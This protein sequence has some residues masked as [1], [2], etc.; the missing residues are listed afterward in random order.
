MKFIFDNSYARE[1]KGFYESSLP[2]AS[3]APE[4][5]YF[6][7]SLANQL[8]LNQQNLNA[9]E[10]A[11]IFSGNRLPE[12]AEPIAQ[13]YAGHQFGQF[14]PQ[15]G[16]GRALILGEI[17]DNDKNRF[18]IC[19]KG[20]G[21]TP[22]SR[23]GDGKAAL[24]AMLREVLIAEAMHA[25]GI[26]TTRSLAVVGTGEQVFRDP[27]QPGAVL[28][29][30]A[31]SHIRIG[32]FQFFAAREQYDKVKTLADYSI[33]RHD[34]DLI[35]DKQR[36]VKFL[37]A[38]INRQAS[39]IAKW[40]GV[41]F[42][43][44]V[45]NT[46][47]ITIAGE[48]IDYGPCAFMENYDP[49]AVFSSI[50]HQGRYAYGNQPAIAQW[51]LARLAE[52]LIPL[53]DSDKDKA[54]EIATEELNGFALAYQNQLRKVMRQKLGLKADNQSLNDTDDKLVTDWLDLLEKNTVD[55]TLAFRSLCDMA[56]GNSEKLLDLFADKPDV[57]LWLAEW[58]KRCKSEGALW[59][60]TDSANESRAN[61]MRKVNPWIIPRNHR[62]EEA[63]Q[64]ASDLNNF[65]LFE[66]LLAAL[67]QP[68]I[69]QTKFESLAIP[70]SAS[71]TD[72]Y[73][74]FCGT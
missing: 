72:N 54:V 32:T 8:Q 40:M 25:L 37:R 10:L 64:A 52:T 71:F 5:V 19:L 41:G 4:L 17:L 14:N 60:N 33:S 27:P 18:D 73:R 69:E 29:R 74:T 61:A 12:H 57:E 63:L 7:S 46:D 26:P 23:G 65:S 42:I 68:Y 3:A 62:V 56:D 51:N 34:S 22:Y 35:D 1:L 9:A 31:A 28:T 20:S 30:T 66:N 59:G 48:T 67:E 11:D 39:L 36:Y 55:F 53:I 24:A 70:A 50:D 38:V 44:G 2:S 16:D 15:L 6:N 13:A 49:K 47:N 45:M 58:Q 21:K 43:H